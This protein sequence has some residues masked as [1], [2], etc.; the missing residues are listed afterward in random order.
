MSPNSQA[1]LEIGRAL[2]TL[3]WRHEKSADDAEKEKIERLIDSLGGKR[4]RLDQ[5]AL[6]KAAGAIA[7]AIEGLAGAVAAARKGP[8]DGYFEKLEAH[9]RKLYA[10]SREMHA[11][12]VLPPATDEGIEP[13]RTRGGETVI[14]GLPIPLAAKDYGALKDEYQIYFDMCETRPPFK[15]NVAYY[16]KKLQHGRPFYEEVAQ[17]TGVPWAFIGV[18]HGMECGFDFG[19]HLHNGDPLTARTFQVP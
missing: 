8:F 1:R 4:S 13:A 5:A 6:L 16:I 10:L 3:N 2:N 14:A 11:E 15:G 12:D 17:Q 18:I 9:L 19:A 7:D